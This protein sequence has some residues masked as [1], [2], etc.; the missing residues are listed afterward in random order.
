MPDDVYKHL[1]VER[2]INCV[3]YATRVGGGTPDQAV[4]NAMADALQCS[5]EMDDLQAAAWRLIAQ[6]TGAEGGIVTC[7][8]G[9]SLTLAA[10]ACIAGNDPDQMDELPDTSRCR[11]SHII[12]PRL[13][14]FDYDHA[15]RL[16]GAVFDTVDYDQPDALG[17]IE[18]AIT[19]KTAAIGYVWLR[20][21]QQPDV[22]SVARLAH[23]HDLP[24]IVDAAF[25]LPPT[26]NLRSC[27]RDGADLVAL[28]GGKHL[29]GPQ[30]SGLLFGRADLVRSAWLQMVDLDVR[31][32]TWSL[33]QWIDAGHI[34]RPPR[35]GIGRSMKVSKESIVGALTALER[36]EARDHA[37][38]LASW[39]KRIDR[40]AREL[41]GLTSLGVSRLFPAPNGQPF[42]VLRIGSEN[43]RV[44]HRRLRG[45]RPRIVL[46]EDDRDALVAYIFPMCLRDDDLSIVI[47]ALRDIASGISNRKARESWQ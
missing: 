45:H 16:S 14:P 28:S 43:M 20:V 46:A 1:G 21:E 23:Q 30:A 4:A 17:Q 22:R 37:A 7:G 3:G 9:A 25:S 39:R 2:V 38:E 18:R 31:A 24:L 29:G 6:H 19:P 34:A 13:G 47:G 5:V 8:A 41:N 40:L 12:Y 26:E 15:I 36:Y 32:E 33:H 42:P 10:A 11:R 27:A 44:I 35:H